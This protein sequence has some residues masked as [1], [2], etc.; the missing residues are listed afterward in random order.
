MIEAN[1][2]HTV[3]YTMLTVASCCQSECSVLSGLDFEA[4]SGSALP[5]YLSNYLL[6]G[7]RITLLC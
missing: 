2:V 3:S 4:A 6:G 1:A 7:H 5:Y